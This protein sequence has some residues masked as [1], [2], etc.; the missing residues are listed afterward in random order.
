VLRVV[1]ST[2]QPRATAAA[3]H[4]VERKLRR[5]G[6]PFSPSSGEFWLDLERGRKRF[7]NGYHVQMSKVK[8]STAKCTQIRRKEFRNVPEHAS[9]AP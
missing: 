6:C 4:L 7:R 2:A 5:I 9:M 8:A 1:A 3:S